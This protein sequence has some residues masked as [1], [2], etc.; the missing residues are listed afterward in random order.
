MV[1]V[2]TNCNLSL[3]GLPLYRD[4]Q[5]AQFTFKFD[6]GGGFILHRGRSFKSTMPEGAAVN[7]VRKLSV[8]RQHGVSLGLNPWIETLVI[9]TL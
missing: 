6:G 1:S 9:G 8:R 7:S 4:P 2:R 3:V 5:S